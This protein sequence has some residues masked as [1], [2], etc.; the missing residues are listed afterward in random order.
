MLFCTWSFAQFF[1]LVFGLY[2]FVPWWRVRWNLPLP[3]GR[4]FTLTGD[5]ARI[6]LLLIASYY[7]YTSWSHKLALIIV[8]STM[9]DY[10]IGLGLEAFQRTSLRRALLTL[11]ITANLSLL[12]YFK[13]SNFFLD[14]LD[15]LMIAAGAPVWF[16]TMHILVPIGISYYTFEAINYTVDVYR[17]LA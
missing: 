17:R 1:V 5:E 16:N 7:F 2:W 10:G 15:E 3:R 11:G 13:Y 6:W 14:S 12:C 9:L 4:R 8:V